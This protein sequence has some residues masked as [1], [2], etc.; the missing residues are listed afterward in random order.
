MRDRSGPARRIIARTMEEHSDAAPAGAPDTWRRLVLALALT[1]A[2]MCAEVAGSLVS[3]SLAL[4][5]DAGHMLADAG[6][7]TLALVAQRIASRP[8]TTSRTYGSRRAE[9]LAAFVNGLALGGT[10][11][12]IVV[13]AVTR[14]RAPS[15]IDGRVMLLVAV[16]GLVVNLAVALTLWHG[17]TP[18]NAN[19]RAALLHVISDAGGSVAAIAA[20]VL[21]LRLGWSRAD[22]FVSV[23]LAALILWGAFRLVSETAQVLMEG[24]PRDLPLPELAATIR[25]TPGVA[26]IHDLHAWTIS[27]GFDVVTVHVVID[28]S[29]HGTEVAQAVGGRVHALHGIAHVT[30]QPEPALPAVSV[31]P[32]AELKRRAR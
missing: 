30:V 7:L 19:V 20:S 1:A 4:L 23:G 13:E 26:D 32:L 10:A 27:D 22:L 9:T 5:S 11:L 29:S 2:G 3:G 21:V 14:W 25:G 8:R 31:Q 28:G 24:A 6:A 18:A 17:H 16:L 12:W 15:A